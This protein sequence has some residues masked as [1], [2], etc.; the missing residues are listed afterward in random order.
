MYSFFF[1]TSCFKYYYL[2]EKQIEI[3]INSTT[4]ENQ[5]A[6]SVC[7]LVLVYYVLITNVL[8]G[9]SVFTNT[10]LNQFRKFKAPKI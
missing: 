1:D 5:K 4:S 10:N 9:M 3:E 2:Y 6:K 8:H 7:Y